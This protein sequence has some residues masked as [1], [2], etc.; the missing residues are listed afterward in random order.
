MCTKQKDF[1]NMKIFTNIIWLTNEKSIQQYL[2]YF[3]S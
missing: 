3:C 1:N 2:W